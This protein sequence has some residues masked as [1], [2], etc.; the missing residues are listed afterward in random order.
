MSHM[1]NRIRR[2]SRD[3]ARLVART[4]SPGR[5]ADERAMVH[6]TVKWIPQM[7][8][9]MNRIRRSSRDV[10]RLVARTSTPVH[11]RSHADDSARRGDGGHHSHGR[12]RAY[13][14]PGRERA[15][16]PHRPARDQ[17]VRRR[18]GPGRRGG[19]IDPG[20]YRSCRRGPPAGT[21]RAAGPLAARRRSLR[22]RRDASGHDRPVRLFCAGVAAAT[23][24]H[25]RQPGAR[26]RR[27]LGSG[28]P[29]DGRRSQPA[30]GTEGRVADCRCVHRRL[31]LGERRPRHSARVALQQTMSSC[32][33]PAGWAGR[34]PR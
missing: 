12:H 7:S 34:S 14:G 30:A 10:A 13:P 6:L 31:F 23:R 5:D 29:R 15:R 20:R 21:R 8:H 3:V 2:S 17:R 11:R 32:R 26:V 24:H 18:P 9:M 1:M 4:S 33:A 28:L 27:H 22:A 19:R 16:V 25:R